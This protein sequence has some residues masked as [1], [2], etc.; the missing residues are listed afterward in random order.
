MNRKSRNIIIVFLAVVIIGV[1]GYFISANRAPKLM[2]PDFVHKLLLTRDQSKLDAI[3]K[4]LT[5]QFPHDTAELQNMLRFTSPDAR[6]FAAQVLVRIGT[7]DA[8][9]LLIQSI[10]VESDPATKDNLTELLKGITNVAGVPA[11]I[12]CAMDVSDLSMHR[13]CRNL[14]S[15]LPDPTVSLDLI[16]KIEQDVG[17]GKM[18]PIIYAVAHL[19]NE[20]A[21][22][23]LISGAKSNS[24]VTARASIEGLGNIATPNSFAALFD[25]IS[26]NNL[27]TRGEVARIVILQ[28]ALASKDASLVATCKRVIE[29]SKNQTTIETAV[30]GLIAI[31]ASE[32]LVALQEELA[33]TKDIVLKSYLSAALGRRQKIFGPGR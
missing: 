26:T 30:D 33:Q 9:Q 27:T 11:L 6:E 20:S 18:E 28:S 4:Q 29:T 19:T 22:P 15:S 31:H 2:T 25:I 16:A 32:A 17:T 12:S 14:L 1:V 7:T 21:I 5:V 10:K 23:A 3:S 13:V 8:I 24:E